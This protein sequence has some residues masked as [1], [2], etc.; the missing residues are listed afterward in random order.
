MLAAWVF[1]FQEESLGGADARIVS[2]RSDSVGKLS[3]SACL[4]SHRCDVKLSSH[5]RTQSL[6]HAAL[7]N[8]LAQS[9][10]EVTVMAKT[11]V[12]EHERHIAAI[13]ESTLQTLIHTDL[14]VAEIIDAA[15]ENAQ[16]MS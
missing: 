11:V 6:P 10:L 14:T 12:T 5:L 8:F 15:H 1:C 16:R 3:R 7:R 13:I 4:L 2:C 9:A